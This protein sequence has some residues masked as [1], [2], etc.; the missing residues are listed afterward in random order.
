VLG[1][2]KQRPWFWSDAEKAA[3]REAENKWTAR[4]LAVRF[5]RSE[6]AVR[7]YAE[8]FGITLARTMTGRYRLWTAAQHDELRA[9]APA[10]NAR[11]LAEHFGRGVRAIADRAYRLGVVLQRL[12]G[13]PGRPA[14]P[15]EPR[16]VREPKPEVKPKQPKPM[17]LPALAVTRTPTALV[18]ERKGTRGQG[19]GTRTTKPR[20]VR[21]E[22]QLPALEWCGKCRAPVSNWQQHYERMG[23]RRSA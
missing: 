4:E 11:Q 1:A 15:R 21:R 9:L 10:R 14:E 17:K 2:G 19:L 7:T 16:L 8:G 12:P 13:Q 18:E 22:A 23:H 6:Q 20:P 3:L 5:N